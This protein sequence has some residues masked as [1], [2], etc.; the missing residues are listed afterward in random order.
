MRPPPAQHER[1][2][3]HGRRRVSRWQR[4]L[5][6]RKHASNT[7]AADASQH[8]DAKGGLGLCLADLFAP[9]VQH[10]LRDLVLV[11]L[12]NVV[13]V[14]LGHGRALGLVARRAVAGVFGN[15]VGA[16]SHQRPAMRQ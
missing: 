13:K 15:R 3:Q 14:V 16:G 2:R 11:G 9:R 12:L 1:S 6:C 7:T 8:A 4:R 10:L 5:Q